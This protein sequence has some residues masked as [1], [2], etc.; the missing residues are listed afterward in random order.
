MKN[1]VWLPTSTGTFSAS[2]NK[3]KINFDPD[4]FVRVSYKHESSFQIGPPSRRD[5]HEQA[6][7]SFFLDTARDGPVYVPAPAQKRLWVVG[8]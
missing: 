5:C 2:F 3:R 1:A 8:K 6:F 4:D 7:G